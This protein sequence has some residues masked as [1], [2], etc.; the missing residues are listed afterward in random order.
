[1]PCNLAKVGVG[2]SNRLARS[3]FQLKIEATKAV[4]RDRFLRVGSVVACAV[5][6][7]LPSHHAVDRLN[8]RIFHPPVRVNDGPKGRRSAVA[9][10]DH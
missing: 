4:L 8:A 6:W 2:R 9:T 7:K 1:M 5:I 10:G 3:S